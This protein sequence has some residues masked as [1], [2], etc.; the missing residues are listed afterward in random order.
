[1]KSTDPRES[2]LIHWL[3]LVVALGIAQSI[4]WYLDIDVEASLS[5]EYIAALFVKIAFISLFYYL[6]LKVFCWLYR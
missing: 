5:L 2:G 3:S 4:F 6:C 1:M